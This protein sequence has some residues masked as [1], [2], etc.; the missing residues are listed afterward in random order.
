M[1]IPHL[2]LTHNIQEF[3]SMNAYFICVIVHDQMWCVCSIAYWSNPKIFLSILYVFESVL[4]LSYFIFVQNCIFY[5]F[6]KN[7]FWGIFTR[8]SRLAF[9]VKRGWGKNL[10]TLNSN[11]DF[12]NCFVTKGFPW[13]VLCFRGVFHEYVTREKCVFSVSKGWCDRF[14]NTSLFPSFCLPHASLNPKLFFT[15]NPINFKFKLYKIII[16]LCFSTIFSLFHLDYAENYL[17]FIDLGIFEK[18]DGKVGF[19]KLCSN[20]WLGF[21]PFVLLMFVLAPCGNCNL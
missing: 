9:P 14:S 19:V 1:T 2:I 7:F 12:R 20:F 3:C 11:K 17:G 10:K 21:V 18:G 16:K 5:V 6:F 4:I 13:K 15:Q 8:S